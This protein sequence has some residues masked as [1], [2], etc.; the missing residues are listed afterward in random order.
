MKRPALTPRI[1]PAE[2]GL[3]FSAVMS[4]RDG[5]D[6]R[7]PWRGVCALAECRVKKSGTGILPVGERSSEEKNADTKAPLA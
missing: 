6:A 5:R 3:A 7:A 1:T 2:R 4:L